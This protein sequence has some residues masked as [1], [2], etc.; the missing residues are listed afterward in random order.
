MAALSDI[1]YT[2]LQK[3]LVLAKPELLAQQISYD[4]DN[5]KADDDTSI[6]T[7]KGI[8]AD[9]RE[10]LLNAP[11]NIDIWNT[12]RKTI[13]LHNDKERGRHS[14]NFIYC[15]IDELKKREIINDE[16]YETMNKDISKKAF[17]QLYADMGHV[18]GSGIWSTIAGKI[19]GAASKVG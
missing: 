8:E 12:L 19:A 16:M 6:T 4:D 11:N 18:H 15:L 3:L 9:T 7:G 5:D 1:S 14:V 2:E 13:A 10:S 17:S